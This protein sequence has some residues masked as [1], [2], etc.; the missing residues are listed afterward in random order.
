M[1]CMPRQEGLLL[2]VDFDS[3][4]TLTSACSGSVWPCRWLGLAGP[5]G[6]E[7]VGGRAVPVYEVQGL[8]RCEGFGVTVL[9][10]LNWEVHLC[11]DIVHVVLSLQ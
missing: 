4:R 2:S 6:P 1:G 3:S 11:Y 8:V 7:H 5:F 10:G 9:Q